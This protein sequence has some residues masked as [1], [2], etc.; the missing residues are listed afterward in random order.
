M[1]VSK[2]VVKDDPSEVSIDIQL[3]PGEAGQWRA[4]LGP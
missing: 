1:P 2:V 3:V 4:L